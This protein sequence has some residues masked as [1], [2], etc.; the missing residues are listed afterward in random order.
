MD[1]FKRTRMENWN[2]YLKEQELKDPRG[3][4]EKDPSEEELIQFVA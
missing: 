2:K 1:V 4:D 3:W